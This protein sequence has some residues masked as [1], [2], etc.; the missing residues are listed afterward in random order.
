MIQNPPF[1][2]SPGHAETDTPVSPPPSRARKIT[3]WSSLLT[4][5]VLIISI[6][7]HLLGGLGAT[8]FVVQTIHAK[9][10]VAFKGPPSTPT[11]SANAL[12]HKVSM[13][14]K[15]N[16]MS[17]PTQARRIAS[18]GLS[19]ITLP[20]MPAT[21]LGT[22]IV[23]GKMAGMGGT[24]IGLGPAG[25]GMG[26]GGGGGGAGINFFGLKSQTKS[27]VFVVDISGS[28]VMH[29]DGRD[30]YD[31]L[32]REV[33]KVLNTLPAGTKF[34]IICFS[35]DI[36][37]YKQ[38]M[39]NMTMVGKEEAIPWLESYSPSRVGKKS[40]KPSADLFKSAEGKR[41][42][43]TS[44]KKALAAAM[45]LKPDTIMFVS[46]GDP[47][48]GAPSTILS[49]VAATQAELS[50]KITINAVAYNAGKNSPASKF[51]SDLAEQNGGKFKNM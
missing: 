27:I 43:G 32:E 40:E 9:R 37:T 11:A 25:G 8:Y 33:I 34:N 36:Y 44:S 41:H 13:A 46:D 17:A 29:K 22:D 50:K 2:R 21:P 4:G 3:L 39:T 23:A 28:M 35:G 31:R 20:D 19:S 18:T 51:M 14:K 1:P 42:S 47:T 38:A 6:I 30:A 24:G 49:A 10:K 26:G 15:Q 16:S 48:D 7:L 12:E 45:A 5:K